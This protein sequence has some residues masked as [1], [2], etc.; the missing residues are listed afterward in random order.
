[1]ITMETTNIKRSFSRAHTHIY[2]KFLL[3]AGEEDTCN[4]F[5]ALH[6]KQ[7]KP[8]RGSQRQG[9]TT[10]QMNVCVCV[11]ASFISI[12]AMKK[13]MKLKLMLGAGLSDRMSDSDYVPIK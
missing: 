12:G 6:A 13:I 4:F 11:C 10:H 9:A 2:S 1:M 8:R 3:Y 7:S 5:H